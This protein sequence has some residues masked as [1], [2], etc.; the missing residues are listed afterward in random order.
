MLGLMSA[1][2][3]LRVA[4]RFGG[5]LYAWRFLAAGGGPVTSS[6]GMRFVPDGCLYQES[7]KGPLFVCEDS[8]RK[9]PWT[10]G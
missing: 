1:V 7:I 5:E 3:P 10:T 6:N 4:N 8:I 2:E 9:R